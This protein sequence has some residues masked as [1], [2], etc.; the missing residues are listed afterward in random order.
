MRASRATRRSGNSNSTD[1]IRRERRARQ[2]RT[3][4]VVIGE[5]EVGCLLVCFTAFDAAHV[6]SSAS[7]ELL[8]SCGCRPLRLAL[9]V[10]LTCGERDVNVR[11]SDQTKGGRDY[12]TAPSTISHTPHRHGAAS[13]GPPRSRRPRCPLWRDESIVSE[14]GG[15]GRSGGARG[16]CRGPADR[17]PV[18]SA[19][20][21]ASHASGSPTR[22]DGLPAPA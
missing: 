10:A 11:A 12:P 18:D 4:V 7:N 9:A 3:S 16:W 13:P 22:Q 21:G 14:A 19:G 15:L 20:P 2:D 17:E 5:A 1:T 8:R 6:L